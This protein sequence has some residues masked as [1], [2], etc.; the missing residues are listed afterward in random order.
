MISQKNLLFY[1]KLDSLGES[2][3]LEGTS[4]LAALQCYPPSGPSGIRTLMS[5]TLQLSLK[6]LLGKTRTWIVGC[7][8]LQPLL[9]VSRIAQMH[10]DRC[11]LEHTGGANQIHFL[12]WWW[13]LPAL[14]G[15]NRVK[16]RYWMSVT[17]LNILTS[18]TPYTHYY[19]PAL[20]MVMTS[21]LTVII[22]WWQI[23]WCWQ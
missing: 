16:G 17:K 4:R 11:A 13:S 14:V 20:V 12:L 3:K 22:I 21:M 5:A 6:H 8:K 23:L 2:F 9:R 15:N 7:R 10:G 19:L 18:Y 1:E